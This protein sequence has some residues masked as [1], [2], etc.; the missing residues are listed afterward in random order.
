MS[1][2]II[3]I[4]FD[5]QALNA[6][7]TAISTLEG[8]LQGLIDLSADERRALPKMGD[9]SEAFCRQTLNVLAQNPQVVA[10]SLNLAEAQRDLQALDALRSRSLR[11]RQLV[12]RVEDSELAL[13]SDVMS[14]ALDG[15]A[16]LKVLGKGS[17]LEMLRKEVGARFAKKSSVEA[18]KPTVD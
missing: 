17:G 18:Q 1:Q 3:S 8:E 15:Y 14:A 6:I 4:T 2:N 10:P 5:D 7:D 12:G 13:G 11:L 16:L 9:K